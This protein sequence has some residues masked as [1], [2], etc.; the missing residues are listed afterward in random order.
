M[1]QEDWPSLLFLPYPPD[2]ANRDALNVAYRP[3]LKAALDRLRRPSGPARLI[4]AIPCPLLQGQLIRSKAF[5]WPQAQSLVAGVYSL[6]AAVC[7]QLGIPTEV[8]GGPGS[9]DATVLLID[10]GRDRRFPAGFRPGIEPNNTIVVDLPTFA[11]AYFPWRYIFSPRSELALDVYHAYLG[12]LEGRQTLRQDQL[13][14]VE[15]G[16]TLNIASGKTNNDRGGDAALTPTYPT[17]CLGGTFDYLHPGHKLLLTA[18]ALLLQV[19]RETG[20][21]SSSPP[22]R[23]IIGITGDEMLRNKKFAEHVQ[24]WAQRARNVMAFLAQLLELNPRGWRDEG[25]SGAAGA[26]SY[27]VEETPAGEQM[28]AAFRGGTIEVL[29]VCIQDAFGPTIT[30]ED[31]QALVVS[32]ETREGGKAVNEERAKKGWNA[33]AVYEVDVLDAEE[34]PAASISATAT[35]T[36]TADQYASKISSTAIRKKRA[37]RAAKVGGT[38]I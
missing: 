8:D 22:G 31:M 34:A 28:R 16:L 36:A 14:P 24:P 5:S 10:H 17:V 3:S 6:L 35:A 26:A 25:Q 30:V 13:I 32:G 33:L 29:C 12:F 27:P 18:G 11:S 7:A 38:K 9:V 23:Y 4:I 15:S 20:P 37:E 21:S 1:S 19:P 2:P